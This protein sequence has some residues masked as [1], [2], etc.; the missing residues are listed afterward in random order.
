MAF[1]VP[2][3]MFSVAFA[4]N[5]EDDGGGAKP[6]SVLLDDEIKQKEREGVNLEEARLK[7][8]CVNADIRRQC[9]SKQDL[10]KRKVKLTRIK[11]LAE[12][13]ISRSERA[14]ARLEQILE[15][16]ESRRDKLAGEEVNLASIDAL[17]AKARQQAEDIQENIDAA[18]AV[19]AT[20]TAETSEDPKKEV[21]TFMRSMNEIKKQ[22][23]DLHKTLNGIVKEMRKVAPKPA[24]EDGSETVPTPT[25]NPAPTNN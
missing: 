4:Q 12:N 22:L 24:T 23:I 6:R 7:E 11:A 15:R 3:L 14:L 17:I 9:L 5:S 25:P 10:E 13:Q 8:G 2:I 19:L 20:G 16:I 1:V 18:K 21:Q